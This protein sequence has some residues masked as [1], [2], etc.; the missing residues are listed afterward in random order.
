MIRVVPNVEAPY[1]LIPRD[2]TSGAR[3]LRRAD[4]LV[5]SWILW[6]FD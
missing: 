5:P 4:A 1:D 2:P 3:D 6:G